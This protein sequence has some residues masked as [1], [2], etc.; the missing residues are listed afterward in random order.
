MRGYGRKAYAPARQA[1]HAGSS[2]AARST[3]RRKPRHLEDT[4]QALL[5]RWLRVTRWQGKPL[6]TFAWHTPNGG[7]RNARTAARL[8]LMGVKPGVPD[9]QL[10]IPMGGYH[11]LFI[12]LKVDGRDT[13]DAQD[14][15]IAMLRERGYRAEVAAG[16]ER[17]AW[18]DAAA[19]IN[20]YLGTTYDY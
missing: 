1:G 4:Q 17:P 10:A 9:V 6:S 3:P 12:E 20:H 5:F 8:K 14:D 15:V 7:Q 18:R 16:R 11:G 19:I 2:P 13:T